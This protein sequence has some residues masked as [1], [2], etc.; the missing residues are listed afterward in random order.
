MVKGI[1]T[2]IIIP[3]IGSL[4]ILILKVLEGEK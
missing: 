2:L 4:D 3:D 1:Y